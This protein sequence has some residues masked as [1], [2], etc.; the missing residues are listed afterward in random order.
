[1]KILYLL[2]LFSSCMAGKIHTIYISGP[3]N[4]GKCNKKWLKKSKI[5][6]DNIKKEEES[7]G[8]TIELFPKKSYREDITSKPKRKNKHYSPNELKS[9]YE[10]LDDLYKELKDL[11]IKRRDQLINLEGFESKVH[12]QS[13]GQGYLLLE[14]LKNKQS[15]IGSMISFDGN[16]QEESTS[17]YSSQSLSSTDLEHLMEIYFNKLKNKGVSQEYIEDK[18]K[19]INN[20][21][22]IININTQDS[23][24]WEPGSKC[25]MKKTLGTLGALA[26][27]IGT[28]IAFI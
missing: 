21:S 19:K 10:Y 6:Y 20:N 27:I 26:A 1:M 3:S 2:L 5:L 24:I 17:S 16:L 12:L 28:I 13:Y 25:S 4:T 18:L 8:N 22:I 15:I 7:N 23:N 9:E 14:K 11:V